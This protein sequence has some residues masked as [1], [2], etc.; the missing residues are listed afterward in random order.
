MKTERRSSTRTESPEQ[1]KL[2]T[3]EP[4]L[5][6]LLN[7]LTMIKQ[8]TDS[9]CITVLPTTAELLSEEAY[10]GQKMMKL[11][12]KNIVLRIQGTKENSRQDLSH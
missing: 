11:I 5:Q 6:S 12:L 9:P 2:L 3:T 4:S 8:L 10:F 1:K 7:I